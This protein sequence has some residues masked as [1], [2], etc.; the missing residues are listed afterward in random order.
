M[1]TDNGGPLAALEAAGFPVASF[2]DEQR[3]VFAGLS[4]EEIALLVDI[5]G[6]LDGVEPDVQAHTMIAG[7]A[8]F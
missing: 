5:K 4:A 1:T 6:R 8:L 7:A 2:T 3:T